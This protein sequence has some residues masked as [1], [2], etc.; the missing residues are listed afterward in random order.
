VSGDGRRPRGVASGPG[1]E[2]AMRQRGATKGPGRA[3]ARS[4]LYAGRG[5]C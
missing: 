5:A 1:C 3:G 2:V 4:G